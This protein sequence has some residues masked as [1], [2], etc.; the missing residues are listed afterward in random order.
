MTT[1]G[2]NRPVK[3]VAQSSQ[4]SVL[5][6]CVALRDPDFATVGDAPLPNAPQMVF[7]FPNHTPYT[8]HHTPIETDICVARKP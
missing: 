7:E 5:R 3:K 2:H 6:V 8:I 1:I 4:S